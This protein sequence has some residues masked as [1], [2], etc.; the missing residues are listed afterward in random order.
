[1]TTCAHSDQVTGF[2]LPAVTTKLAT[3][4]FSPHPENINYVSPIF[5]YSYRY[6]LPTTLEH[7]LSINNEF[8]EL[9]VHCWGSSDNLSF[10]VCD[11]Y[12]GGN[13]LVLVTQLGAN[14]RPIQ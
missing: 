4:L 6:H 3:T 7:I 2:S 11:R 5:Y 14:S 12:S 10:E 9:L 8:G 13:L 1:M